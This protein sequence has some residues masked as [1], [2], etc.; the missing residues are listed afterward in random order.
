MEEILEIK[1]VTTTQL[2]LLGFKPLSCLKDY[3][4]LK[5]STFLFPTDEVTV[6]FVVCGGVLLLPFVKMG[7]STAAFAVSL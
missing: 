4:N 3:H 5:P 2:R 7:S 1:R 6:V